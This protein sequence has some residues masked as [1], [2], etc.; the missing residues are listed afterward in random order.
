[1]QISTPLLVEKAVAFP[2]P[3]YASYRLPTMM[4]GQLYPPKTS[5][6]DT[7]APYTNITA[8]SN[9]KPGEKAKERKSQPLQPTKND[10]PTPL[11]MNSVS[12]ND[13][14]LQQG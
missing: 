5:H 8:L 13:P 2:N 11:P 4:N 9:P 14:K 6:Q 10:R 3:T 12:T 7:L 1:M